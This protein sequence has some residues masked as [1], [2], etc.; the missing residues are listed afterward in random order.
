MPITCKKC[1]AEILAGNIDQ[2]RG[3]ATCPSCKTIF[4]LTDKPTITP[5]LAFDWPEM[6]LPKG[7]SITRLNNGLQITRRWLG[8]SYAGVAVTCLV[9]NGFLLF[10][11]FS[12][13]SFWLCLT[14][15]VWVG[16]GLF[17]YTLAGLLNSTVITIQPNLLKIEHGP[18]PFYFNKQF[19]PILLKQLYTKEQIHRGKN[20]TH[21]TYDIYMLGWDGRNQKLL[22]G[23]SSGEQA[24]FLEQELERFLRIEDKPVPG[25]IA[26]TVGRYGKVNWQAWAD[27]AKANKLKFTRGKLLQNQRVFGLYRGYRLELMAFPAQIEAEVD[28]PKVRLALAVNKPAAPER[29]NSAG[30]R[31]SLEEGVALLRPGGS[32][33]SLDGNFQAKARGLEI[34]YEQF[35]IETDP[36]RLHFLFERL[37]GLIEAYPK[38]VALGGEIMPTLESIAVDTEHPLRGV[39]EQLAQDI[40]PTTLHIYPHLS[41][42]RCKRC[43]AHCVAHEA[44]LASQRVT[45]YGCRVCRQSH[46]FFLVDTIIAVLDQRMPAEPVEQGNALRV[47][48][49]PRRALFDF[50]EVEIVQ[51]ADEEV[52]RFAVQ[53][54]NDTDPARQPHYKKMRCWV[55]HKAG[56]SDNSLRILRYTFDQLEIR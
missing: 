10:F 1:Q 51:A 45:Y 43:L 39:A 6:I 18:L 35:G 26:G 47:N 41:Q 50:D 5:Q 28:A 29:E 21:Y 11:F 38:M 4:S 12:S 33:F 15:H 53:V 8:P 46:D 32:R 36:A 54:G 34:S 9:W 23:L 14:P 30:P 42:L 24:L 27:F 25:E 19:D 55:A 31:L 20:S 7:V 22:K 52:E 16:I 13:F 17:Y 3:L 37:A 49:L 40:A 2:P 44:R 48:W 56:L